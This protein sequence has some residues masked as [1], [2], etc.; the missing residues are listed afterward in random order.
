[1]EVHKLR[2]TTMNPHDLTAG[3]DDPS[4]SKDVSA[5]EILVQR[6]TAE[7]RRKAQHHWTLL[8]NSVKHTVEAVAHADIREI[9]ISHGIHH[10]RKL[11]HTQPLQNVIFISPRKEYLTTDGKVFNVFME[12]GRKKTT[13]IP[14]EPMNRV[15]Y[16]THTDQYVGWL[17]DEEMLYL[18]DVDFEIISQARC[19]G[20]ILLGTYNQNTGEMVTLGSRF[21]QSW[22]F[23]YGARHLIPRL[24]TR[25]DFGDDNM[26][27]MIVLEETASHTQRAFLACGLGVVVYN[28]YEG[29]MLAHRKELHRRTITAMTFFNP[30]KYLVT[31][32]QDGSIKIWD[33]DWHVVMVFVGHR[34]LVNQ[35]TVYPHGPSI[36]SASLDC[37]IRVWNM[38]TCDEVDRI[39]MSEPAEGLGTS[40]QYDIFHTFAGKKVDLWRI[41]HLY[42]MHT[43]VGHRVMSIKMTT[44]PNFVMRAVLMC[45][46]SSIRIVSPPSGNVLTTMMMDPGKSIIDAAYAIEQ[47]MLF[48]VLGN[49]D[50][51]KCRTNTNP[52]SLVARWKCQNANDV[53]NYLLVYE[54]VVDSTARHDIWALM[55]KGVATRSI[56]NLAPAKQSRNRTLLL[57]G[58]RDGYIC[59]FNWE[60]GAVDFK[61]EA[62]GSKGVLNMIANSRA[63]Q[64]ISAGMDN[65]IKVWRL[66]PFAE[67]ALTPLMS[68]Y[69]AHTPSFMTTIKTRLCVAFQDPSSATFSTVLYNLKDK[70][71]FDHKPDDDHLDLI[72]GM[73]SCPRM[74][75][76]ATCSM[77]GT[78]RIWNETNTLIRLLRLNTMPLSIGF[79]SH[80]GDLL[81]GT[82][83]HLFKIPYDRYLPRAYKFRMVSMKFEVEPS[84]EPVAYDDNLLNMLSKQDVKRLKNSKSSF[85]F[86][87]FVDLLSEEEEQEVVKEKLVKKE[88]FSELEAREKELLRI[89]DGELKAKMKP[90]ATKETKSEAFLNYMKMFYD[91]PKIKLPDDDPFPEDTVKRRLDGTD[92]PAEEEFHGVKEPAGFFPPR[93]STPAKPLKPAYPINHG[94]FIPNSVLV[95]L[96]WPP[97]RPVDMERQ[98]TYAP[99]C[100]TADQLDQI[101]QLNKNNDPSL[102]EMKSVTFATGEDVDTVRVF[103]WGDDDDDEDEDGLGTPTSPQPDGAG[104]RRTSVKSSSLMSKMQ[105]I[106]TRTPSPKEEEVVLSPK[107]ASPHQDRE[108]PESS[109]QPEAPRV[110]SPPKRELKPVQPIRKLVSRPRVPIPSPSPSPDTHTPT[111][112][113]PPTPLPNFIKQFIGTEWFE[114]Y[115][116]NCTEKTMPKPWNSDTLANMILKLIRIAE[117]EHKTAVVEALTLLFTQESLTGTVTVQV[118]KAIYSALNHHSKPPTCAVEAEKAF[119]LSSVRCLQVLAVKDMDFVVEMMVQFLDGDRDV[120]STIMDTLFGCGLQDPHHNFLK[121][122]DSWDIWNLDDSDRKMELRRM[123]Q[124]WLNRWMTSYKLHIEDTIDRMK[125]GQNVHGKMTRGQI[126]KQ[127][128]KHGASAGGDVSDDQ[129]TLT[130]LPDGV[131]FVPTA[132]RNMTITYDKMPDQTVLEA[133]T[134]LDAVSYFCEM[135]VEKE[136]EALK[137]GRSRPQGPSKDKT[138]PP[139]NTVLV[140]PKLP[141]KAAL[142]RLGETHTSVCRRSRDKPVAIDFQCPPLGGRNRPL[143]TGEITTFVPSINLPMKTLYMNP[144]PNR[145][146]EFDARFQEPV[147]ITLKSS[148]KFFLPDQSYIPM[149]QVVAPSS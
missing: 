47:E 103:D 63:D 135:M 119:I 104:S 148:Q 69:C 100:L 101:N 79:C 128:G 51:I 16:S 3:N 19:P 25:T 95:K 75:L 70:D 89:R 140:L 35:L 2:N 20:N 129:T 137:K 64:V 56:A 142:V 91:K 93:P 110:P 55:K 45:R 120:R 4:D 116:P 99:P 38:E 130:T 113:P 42:Q 67:E 15:V 105:S 80:K 97:P 44:H 74:K 17:Q 12:D 33:N 66:Y 149:E 78:V 10:E 34:R 88:A 49:G 6:R 57:G 146:D 1:M 29:K 121:E 94:G 37:T 27:S 46:D 118:Q 73:T 132:S 71:R 53:C 141:H 60:T 43:A 39:A 31:G 82:G 138:G 41:Q 143:V 117:L 48:T 147:L 65:V 86:E 114:K 92:G 7:E 52:C 9:V 24:T 72:T 5:L 58:R 13:V 112:P 111:P 144:F 131:E 14:E 108:S 62:H 85:K 122:L 124:Q 125:K 22:S 28:L 84:E 23:R 134:Y 30:L 40:M 26:F 11:N 81:L 87:H 96:L 98:G 54:Y 59:V 8:R 90:M 145:L 76:F 32:A 61:V 139:K 123:C 18:L 107:S 77:D 36:I 106:M 127:Q 115:F 68:F 21:L 109:G 136:I 102:G 83:D 133:V 50:I 126:Q